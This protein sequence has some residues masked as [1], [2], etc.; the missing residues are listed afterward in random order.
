MQNLAMKK[1]LDAGIAYDV[2][3]V[4]KMVEGFEGVV[5]ELQRYENDSDYCDAVQEQWIWSIGQRVTDKRIFAATD[6]RFY[7]NP[8]FE[9]L[10]LR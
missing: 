6:T 7:Q 9:C 5:W 2:N 8:M 4:G 10:W 3:A 1:K